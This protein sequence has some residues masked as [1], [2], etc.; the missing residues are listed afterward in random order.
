MKIKIR[1]ELKNSDK[2][3]L[4]KRL[5]D[6]RKALAKA[7]LDHKQFKLKNTSSLTNMRQEIAVILTTLR[8]KELNHGK[9][10]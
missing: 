3:E 4:M 5:N 10:A 1:Q 7:A 2:A 6:S 9:E 8:E